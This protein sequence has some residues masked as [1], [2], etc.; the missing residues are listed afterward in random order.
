MVKRLVRT[1]LVASALL[2]LAVLACGQNK[3]SN[4]KLKIGATLPLTG[5]IASYGVRVQQG[6]EIALQELGA[7]NLPSISIEFQDDGN[8][9]KNAVSIMTS[10]CTIQRYPVVIGAG[11]SSVSLAI[12]PLANQYHV[13]QISPL[14]S[15][16]DLAEKGGSYFFRVCPADDQQARILAEWVAN[17]K[18]SEIGLIYTN[19]SWGAGLARSFQ[20]YYS[21]KRG[22][23]IAVS[24]GLTEGQ[25]DFRT[26]LTKIKSKGCQAIVSPTYPKD[27]GLLVSSE[28]TMHLLSS[29]RMGVNLGLIRDLNIPAVNEL[30]IR[31]QPAHLQKLTGGELDTSDRNIERAG[32]LRRHLNKETDNG[33]A[34]HN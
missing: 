12:A 19:N 30:F 33:G 8:I 22:G 23:E 24:E 1:F 15:S 20:K 27:G 9:A 34:E 26:V 13:V 32:F 17:K 25:T 14:S 6:A 3:P 16:E 18:Y 21:E 31:T 5:D 11:G 28:E 4:E 10:F 2:S 7:R 29:V